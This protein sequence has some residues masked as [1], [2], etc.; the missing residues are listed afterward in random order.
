M[1]YVR[2]KEVG[3]VTRWTTFD[4][5]GKRIETFDDPDRA[6][7]SIGQCPV[8]VKL[9]GGW[10]SHP[11]KRPIKTEGAEMCNLHLGAEKRREKRREQDRAA[12]QARLD[13]SNLG[14]EREAEVQC[15]LKKLGIDDPY[16]VRIGSVAQ[17]G[18][19]ISPGTIWIRYETLVRLIELA[20]NK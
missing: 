7:L 14:K 19:R 15:R 16:G 1:P 20:E 4:D 18:Y 11:C 12:Q 5:Q 10:R 6:Y 8:Q 3:N 9:Q 13:A 17:D 2:A